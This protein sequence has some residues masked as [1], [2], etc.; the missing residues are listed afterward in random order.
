M[1]FEPQPQAALAQRV[2]RQLARLPQVE[3]VALAG[4]QTSEFEDARSDLDL[5][6][7]VH[8]PIPLEVRAAIA[9]GAP[10]AEIGNDFWEPGDEWKDAETGI[11]VDLMFR[12][13]K[14]IEE[15]LDR[16]LKHHGASVGY[17]TCFWYNVLHSRVLFDRQG[18]FVNLQESCRQPTRRNS[19]SGS[20]PR[21][22]R[23]C[24]ATCRP[25]CTKSSWRSLALTPS[26]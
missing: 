14:W 25:I 5:Y 20:S 3:A 12:H 21:M 17:S 6:V 11:S 18:W 24:A 26:A 16:V 7:Y 19:S 13:A 4:S 15:Q 2:T 22:I 10:R 9:A 23:F 1:P 8:E